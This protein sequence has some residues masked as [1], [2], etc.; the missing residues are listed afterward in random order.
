MEDFPFIK[1]SILPFIL[2]SLTIMAT[3]K[4]KIH[5]TIFIFKKKNYVI[6]YQYLIISFPET[7]EEYNNLYCFIEFVG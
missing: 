6:F 3:A 5:I 2:K 1:V 7:L 4:W